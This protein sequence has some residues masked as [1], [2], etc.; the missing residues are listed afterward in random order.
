MLLLLWVT[1]LVLVPVV[2]PFFL[3]CRLR[4]RSCWSP[5]RRRLCTNDSDRR[6]HMLHGLP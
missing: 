3:L 4:S 6:N 1:V 2:R 5:R